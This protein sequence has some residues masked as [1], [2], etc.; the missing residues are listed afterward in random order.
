MKCRNLS[1]TIAGLISTPPQSQLPYGMLIIMVTWSGFNLWI[2]GNYFA[3]ACGVSEPVLNWM[4]AI[5][6]VRSYGSQTVGGF[7]LLSTWMWRISVPRVGST[8][9]VNFSVVGSNRA[10]LAEFSMGVQTV[11]SS[12]L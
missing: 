8:N 11:Y 10:I 1:P 12:V 6:L 4:R 5:L 7:V 3:A 2:S 9:S